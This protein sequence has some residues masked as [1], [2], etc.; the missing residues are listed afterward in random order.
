[1]T[2]Q[3]SMPRICE[4]C[5]NPCKKWHYSINRTRQ[6]TTQLVNVH[7]DLSKVSGEKWCSIRGSKKSKYEDVNVEAYNNKLRRRLNRNNE[8]S[9]YTYRYDYPRKPEGMSAF[10]TPQNHADLVNVFN[11]IRSHLNFGTQELSSTNKSPDGMTFMNG[12]PVK[13]EYELRSCD[14]KQHLNDAGGH[15]KNIVD[16]VICWINND[17]LTKHDVIVISL[18]NWFYR[19]ARRE[20]GIDMIDENISEFSTYESEWV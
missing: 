11:S 10:I 12:Y 18:Y 17:S 19:G 5:G 8:V 2:Q 3:V 9:P 14:A 6:G 4:I 20:N 16:I 15:L 7:E 13:V 1:M